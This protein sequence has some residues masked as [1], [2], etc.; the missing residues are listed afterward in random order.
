MYDLRAKCPQ[1][2]RMG[3]GF[4]RFASNVRGACRKTLDYVTFLQWVRK[5]WLFSEVNSMK[6]KLSMQPSHGGL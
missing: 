2:A 1:G 3:A 5:L 6:V 4:M